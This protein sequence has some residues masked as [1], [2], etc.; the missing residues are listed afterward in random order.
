MSGIQQDFRGANNY[1]VNISGDPVNHADNH[2]AHFWNLD[3]IRVPV[4]PSAL[5]GNSG[6]NIARSDAFWQLDFTAAKDFP[7]PWEGS[8]VQFR[9]EFF[10]MLNRT[11]FLPPSSTCGSW[12]ATT[13]VCTQGNFGTITATFDPR[14][15]QF[16]VKVNF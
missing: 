5:F 6:R 3:N 16:G 4:D 8:R 13:G 1:R 14:L 12:N 7:L 10:N 9:A 2:I 11:N 15:V